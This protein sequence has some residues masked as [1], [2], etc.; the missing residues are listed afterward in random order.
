MA[1]E[2]ESIL[3]SSGVTP[4]TCAFIKGIPKVGLDKNDIQRL[5]EG[6]LKVSRRDIGYTIAKQ[7]SGGTTIA[8]TMILSNFA[9]IKIFATGGLG[10]VHRGADKTMDISADLN[11]LGKTPV[12][13]VCA[14]PK[15]ILDI[16]LT[17]EYLETQGVFVGTYKNKMIPGF[18]N[19]N[20]GIKS[21]YTFDT[22]QEAAR[23]IKNSLNGSVLCIP[24][25]NNLNIN[26]IIDELIQTAPVSG[27]ELTPYLLS[28][29]AKRT[30]GR[31]VDVNIDLVKNNVKAA[32]EIAK[33][34][35]KLGDEVF[36]PVIEPGFDPIPP[37]PDKVDVTVIGSVALDTYAT[38]NTTKFHD[39]NIGTIQQSI[40]GVGYNIAKAASYICNSK[41]ISRISKEDAHKVD[42]NSSLVYGKTAQ[43]ISTHDSNGDLIIACAD[44]SAIEEDFEI[45]PES[46]IVVFDCNL[47]PSTMNKV[48][49]KSKTNIIEPTSH[50]K[51]KRIG[52]LN[53]G[54]YPNNQVKLITPTIAELSSIYESMKHKFDIDEWFPIIDSIKPDYNKLDAKLLEKGVFQQCFS[55]LPFFQNILVKLGGDGVLLVSLCQQEH[56]KLD[57]GYSKRFGNA[58]VEYFPIPKENENLKIVNV[59][60]AGDTFVGYLAGKLSKT[61][62]LQTNL[63][64]DLVQ[65]KYDIIYKSQLAAG[66]SLTRIPLLALL[67]FRN[68]NETVEVDNS[69]NPF[70]YEIETPTRKYQLLGYGVR[71]VTFISFKVYGIAIYIDKNDIPKLKEPTDD[72]IRDMVSNCNFLVRL[73]PVRNTDFNHLKDGLI[74][75]ILAHESSKQL[76]LNLGLQELRDAFKIRGSVPKN[77]LLF[78][79]FNKG[80]MNFSYANKKEYKEMGK[81]TDPQIG[82]QLF[83]QYLGKKPLS[84]SLKESCVNQINSLI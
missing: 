43:Y 42:V 2:V 46:D 47:S 80:L 76:D 51:A 70:P 60:G 26:H 49:D 15:A 16:G 22:Y 6:D 11:E 56:V 3:R 5:N 9:G 29:I 61:N 33:E 36:T 81:I 40:G 75:S 19:D 37:R 64:K 84:Q 68:I 28:E 72:G 7:L 59:T 23:I 4:A 45:K 55:L 39:S 20:S 78:M 74:K 48:L 41:L 25:P 54:V 79:E 1:L 82:T 62:W 38:L 12:S 35:Y 24:P 31:S 53:L 67:P 52:Q 73:T 21:P 71:S 44:M 65:S 30:E 77:D 13:V 17:M 66:L 83:L 32:A 8:S 57:S 34:Y 10:G 18:Y 63:T 27:K 50:F 69:I 58:I 14:G